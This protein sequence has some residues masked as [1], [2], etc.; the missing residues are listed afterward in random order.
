MARC[1]RPG[2]PAPDTPSAANPYKLYGASNIGSFGALLAYP[3]LF[4]PFIGLTRQSAVWAWGFG[5]LI[6]CLGLCGAM[7]LRG[8][9]TQ[10]AMG[11]PASR[12]IE[13]KWNWSQFAGWTILAAI[14]S[15]LLVSVTAHIS[16]DIASAPLLW[17]LPLALY[18]LTFVIAFRDGFILP[19]ATIAPVQIF[20]TMLM[21]VLM[22][23]GGTPLLV[24]LAIHLTFF[25]VSVLLCHRALYIQR[26]GH[27]DLTAFYVAMSLGGLVGG[28]FAGLLAPNIFSSVIEYPLLIVAIL[29]CQPRIA[30]ALRA[31]RWYEFAMPVALLALTWLAADT[32]SSLCPRHHP[33]RSACLLPRHC[34]LAQLFTGFNLRR[35]A[36]LRRCLAAAIAVQFPIMALVLRRAQGS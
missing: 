16:T 28:L 14:P 7:A 10:T 31:A 12:H 35:C 1:C 13:G 9:N 36:V 11:I 5:L 34:L 32:T 30:Q 3:F 4:E 33:G 2:L 17:V 8:L 6:L 23:I 15:G 29:L 19:D 20:A 25:F 18:L 26:P 27:A 22:L 24:T 21:L